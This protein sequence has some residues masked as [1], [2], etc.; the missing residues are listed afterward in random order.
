MLTP[1]N[2]ILLNKSE[3]MGNGSLLVPFT[4]DIPSTMRL[5]VPYYDRTQEEHAKAI[6]V[7][8]RIKAALWRS[9]YDLVTCC[10]SSMKL[11]IRKS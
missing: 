5:D 10:F 7:I 11:T 9:G 6:E 3:P 2:K 4:L 8:G 1:M